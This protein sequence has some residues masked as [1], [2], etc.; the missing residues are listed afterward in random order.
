MNTQ[1][2]EKAGIGYITSPAHDS[3][4][5]TKALDS[6]KINSGIYFD[7]DSIPTQSVASPFHLTD[8]L[9]GLSCGMQVII[10]SVESAL[11]VCSCNM[12]VR[13]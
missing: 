11:C 13:E 10:I 2:K 7:S 5:L 9:R 4:L 12:G 1:Q 3:S 8:V 6:V